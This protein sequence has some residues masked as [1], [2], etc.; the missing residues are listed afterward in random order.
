M[1][2]DLSSEAWTQ[3][4]SDYEHTERPIADICAEHGISSGTLRDRMRRWHWT[5]RRAPI[6]REGPPPAQP[7]QID[8]AVALLPAVP[9]FDAAAPSLAD[10]QQIETAVPEVAAVPQAAA[11]TATDA[12]GAPDDIAIVPR[13]Q[14]AVARVLPAIEA[15]LARLTA[16]PAHA[17]EME[18]AARALSSL[19]RT[20]RELNGLLDQHKVPAAADRDDGPEDIDEFRRELARRMN[21]FRMARTGEAE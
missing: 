1:A 14:S 20:L 6:P 2:P 19:T 7:P 17:R 9:A 4:R 13:L 5:R 18:Q 21:A 8:A 10:A 11:G 3:I 15:T 12:S 16:G